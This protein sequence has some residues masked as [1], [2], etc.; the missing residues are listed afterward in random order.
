MPEK[1][2]LGRGIDAILGTLDDQQA[3][4]P[5]TGLLQIPPD[6]I[7]A[8]PFQPR[9]DFDSDKA[10]DAFSDLKASIE[11]KGLVQPITVRRVGERYQVIAGERRLRACQELGMA[12]IPAYVM[13]VSEDVDMMELALIENLQR[14]NLN[15]LEEAE[16]YSLLSGKY[17]MSH[18]EIAAGIGKSRAAVTNALRLLKLP[19]EIKTA[20]KTLKISAGHARAL[21]ALEN[22]REQIHVFQLLLRKGLNVRETE[23]LVARLKKKPGRNPGKVKTKPPFLRKS[24]EVLMGRFGTRVNI[25]SGRKKGVIEIEYFS[26][27][28]LE[29]LIELL[30]EHGE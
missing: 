10:R 7:D 26:Q 13:D 24:E 12:A 19:P 9:K 20:L 2:R 4:T 14:D 6:I 23:A 27:D 29:R 22:S 28:D 8:N 18:E 30:L 25:R 17:D 1:P 3:A 15:P 11:A 16:A 5:Q 21:L